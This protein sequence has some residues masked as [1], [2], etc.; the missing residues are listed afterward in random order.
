MFKPLILTSILLGITS[1]A[2]ATEAPPD[3]LWLNT[4]LYYGV[5]QRG[6][7]Y[8][9]DD[10]YLEVEFGG[11]KG[12]LDLY[13]YIDVKNVLS[14][15]SISDVDKNEQLFIDIE[16]RLSIDRMLN[17]DLSIGAIKEWF[18]AFDYYY[19]DHP[20]SSGLNVLWSG[21]GTNTEVPWLGTVGL[22]AYARYIDKNYGASHEGQWDGYVAHLNWFKPIKFFGKDRFLAFQGYADYEFG[23]DMPAK[24]DPFEQ[25]YRTKDSFQSYLG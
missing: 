3:T 7:P 9:F 25:I 5:D 8:K 17:K 6:G 11:R 16:P 22:N 4:Y 10:A 1:P 14:S 13:G 2:L 12:I 18:V 21:I 19:A 15:T 23:S 24:G 20:S